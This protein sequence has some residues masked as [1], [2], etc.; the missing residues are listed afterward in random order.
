MNDPQETHLKVLRHLQDNPSIT[1]RELAAALGI[2]LGKANYCMQAL[3]S[4]GMVKA[5]NFKNSANKRA[6]LYVLT[7][8]GIEAKARISVRFLQKKVEEYEALRK[9]IEQLKV[10]I[11]NNG[12]PEPL[13][14]SKLK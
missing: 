6:Y 3:I 8:K 2:S 13:K 12:N 4:K 5:N 11:E 7:P 10:E 14:P 1:Q 9:E